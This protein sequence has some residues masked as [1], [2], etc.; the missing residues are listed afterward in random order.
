MNRQELTE[1]AIHHIEKKKEEE[2]ESEMEDNEEGSK[3]RRT[4][5]HLHRHRPSEDKGKVEPAG[6]PAQ[7]A[8]P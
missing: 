8:Y 1:E 3:M 5:L 6:E 4:S 2:R 7:S